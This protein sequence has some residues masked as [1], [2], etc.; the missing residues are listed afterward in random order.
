MTCVTTG[1]GEIQPFSDFFRQVLE[2]FVANM[3][4]MKATRL[5][6]SNLVKK[7]CRSAARRLANFVVLYQTRH[8]RW[9][10]DQK[11]VL[12]TILLSIQMHTQKLTPLVVSHHTHFFNCDLIHV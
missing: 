11:R 4:A 7:P 10:F 1:I 6:L 12:S 5:R 8:K 3:L 9:S 2:S